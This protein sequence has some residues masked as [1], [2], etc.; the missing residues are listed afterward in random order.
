VH[1]AWPGTLG[2]LDSQ[3]K[4]VDWVGRSGDRD[5]FW[6]NCGTDEGIQRADSARVVTVFGG[7]PLY[8]KLLV[9]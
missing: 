3:E 6:P 2:A 1:Y 7:L 4:A 9:C 5:F 8:K